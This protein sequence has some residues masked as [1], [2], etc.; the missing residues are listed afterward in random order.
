MFFFKINMSNSSDVTLVR[1]IATAPLALR[2][3]QANEANA[4]LPVYS[5]ETNIRW[6]IIQSLQLSRGDFLCG[7]SGEPFSNWMIVKEALQWGVNS[8][9]PV[10]IA[11]QCR[12]LET[13][14]NLTSCRFRESKPIILT[15][16][17]GGLRAGSELYGVWKRCWTSKYC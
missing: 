14:Y 6:W 16:V 5:R 11:I 8:F 12:F 4:C 17:K 10:N 1:K 15:I 13:N 9:D 7:D 3:C 2:S